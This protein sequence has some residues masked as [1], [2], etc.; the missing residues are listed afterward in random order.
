MD[1][2]K[3]IPLYSLTGVI[4]HVMR[5]EPTYSKVEGRLRAILASKL[6]YLV[7][8]G[9]YRDRERKR[10]RERGRILRLAYWNANSAR[11][12]KLELVQFLSDHDI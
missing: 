8:Y 3:D 11:N 2:A 4:A 1:L 7:N 10:E 5:E 12:K 9:S 6:H